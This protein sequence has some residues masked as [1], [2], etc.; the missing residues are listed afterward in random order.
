MFENFK[1]YDDECKCTEDWGDAIYLMIPNEIGRKDA[2]QWLTD[3]GNY[4]ETQLMGNEENHYYKY[5]DCRGVY[6]PV[7][8]IPDKLITDFNSYFPKESKNE[9][10]QK[11][12]IKIQLINGVTV[13]PNLYSNNL[14]EI[15]SVI[16]TFSSEK[17]FAG[18]VKNINIELS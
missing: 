11:F 2:I 5:N 10:S 9:I 1:A 12:K 6:E 15:A 8:D 16:Q 13:E 4:Y 3:T 18:Q 17:L 7:D 14:Y